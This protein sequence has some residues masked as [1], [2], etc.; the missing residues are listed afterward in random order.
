MR[1]AFLAD[2]HG[3]LPAFEAA[4]DHAHRQRP[5]QI[6]IVGDI[7]VGSPDS[8]A[9]LE[10]ACSLGCPIVRGNHERYV[11]SFGQPNAPPVWQSNQYAPVRWAH[12]Q[13]TI[14][15]RAA[16]DALP[17]FLRLADCPDL[18]IVHA[19][20]RNDRDTVY[21]YTPDDE[22]AAMFPS[23]E[24][25]IVRAHNHVPQVRLW[26][27]RRIITTGSV[28][29]ALN[30]EPTAQYLLLDRVAGEWRIRHQSVPYDQ[31]L[32][33]ARFHESGYLEAAGPMARLFMR[34]VATAAGQIVPF[35]RDY[36]RWNAA[37]PVTLEAAV[38]RFFSI[39]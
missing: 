20:L 24:T 25:T 32:A 22:I 37:G 1:L 4:L 18:L 29:L 14:E 33:L 6:I 16:A 10:L 17:Q 23:G 39:S 19:S 21:A 11:A 31:A 5:D 8:R 27:G 9:C 7:V 26:E 28:G 15:Q 36:E 30:L 34:E 38:E 35:L 2:I 12:E 13:L 3:N